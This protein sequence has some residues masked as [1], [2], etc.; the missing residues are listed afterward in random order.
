MGQ[1]TTALNA[2]LFVGGLGSNPANSSSIIDQEQTGRRSPGTLN[3]VADLEMSPLTLGDKAGLRKRLEDNVTND[4]LLKRLKDRLDPILR[5]NPPE[6]ESGG[7]W[8]QYVKEAKSTPD[9]FVRFLTAATRRACEDSEGY[10]AS[11][12]ARRAKN[13]EPQ[14]AKQ[15]AKA[16]LNE[17]CKGARALPDQTR[18]KLESLASPTE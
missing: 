12:M 11:S 6:W 5:E 16:L 1:A 4:K 7:R 9:E 17:H 13:Y 3:G 15:L 8:R 18:A 2:L 14:Y 10:M